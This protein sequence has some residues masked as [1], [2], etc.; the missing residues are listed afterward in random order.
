MVGVMRRGLRVVS[1]LML[2]PLRLMDS[3]SGSVSATYD[4]RFRGI[5]ALRGGTTTVL[6][7]VGRA[8]VQESTRVTLLNVTA[9]EVSEPGCVTMWPYDRSRPSCRT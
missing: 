1:S 8:E 7:F 9:N 2:G 4:G 6:Q 5:G 3:R